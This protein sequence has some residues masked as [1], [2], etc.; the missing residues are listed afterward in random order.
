MAT[1][2]RENLYKFVSEYINQH[3]SSPSFADMTDAMGISP[4]S[5]SLITRS[6]RILEK[7]RK[8]VLSKE[9]RRLLISLTTKN[10]PLL[11]RISAGMPIEAISDCQFIDVNNLFQVSN[12]FALLVKGTSMIDEGI[13]DGDIIIC[14]KAEVANEG[15]I[16]VALIDQHNTTLKRL[17]FKMKGM[18]TLVPAN[19]ELKPRAYARERIRIQGIY[20]GLVRLSSL[21]I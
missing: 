18:I 21:R 5:K 15:D 14:K 1:N 16:V 13:L 11:G 17:S 3:G 2:F 19:P 7:E 12:Q 9:G 20:V 6:L 10:L 8:L 4:R